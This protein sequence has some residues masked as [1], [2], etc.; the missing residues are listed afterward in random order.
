MK[1]LK[2]HWKKA[3]Q[4][5]ME[6][7]MRKLRKFMENCPANVEAKQLLTQMPMAKRQAHTSF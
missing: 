6:E 7:Q 2:E 5:E 4:A 1:S 3:V